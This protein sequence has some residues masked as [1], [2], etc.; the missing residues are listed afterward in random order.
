M[1]SK[2]MPCP[3]CGCE[4]Q[5]VEFGHKLYRPV[6]NHPLCVYCAD[7]E[8]LFGYD[9]DYGGIFDTK[10]EA[11]KAWNRRSADDHK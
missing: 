8:L 9:V 6:M 2:L 10:E 7:C 3:F 11:T 5:I 4:V 1:E